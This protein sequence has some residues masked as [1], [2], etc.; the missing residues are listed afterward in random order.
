MKTKQNLSDR[1]LEIIS[2]SNLEVQL[3]FSWFSSEDHFK[4]AK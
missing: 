4:E 2:I 1:I 3:L